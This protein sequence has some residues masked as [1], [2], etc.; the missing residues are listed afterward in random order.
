MLYLGASQGMD[1]DK[2]LSYPLTMVP[3]SLSHV[4]GSMNKTDKSTLM[5]KLEKNAKKEKPDDVD[6]YFFDA[7]FFLRTVPI[8]PGTYG[9]VAQAI[10]Q[11]ACKLAEE[12]DIV[13][14]T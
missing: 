12:V 9:G 11:H 4:N 6:T 3:L 7:M 5:K 14:D 8:L 13:C 10:L 2:V 1:L